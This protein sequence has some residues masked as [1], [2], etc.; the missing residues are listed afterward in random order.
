MS[1]GVTVGNVNNVI[2]FPGQ[3]G[4]PALAPATPHASLNVAR[5]ARQRIAAIRDDKAMNK[6]DKVR[7]MFNYIG[8][9]EIQ[10]GGQAIYAE[11]IPYHFDG[12]DR[13]LYSV[14]IKDAEFRAFLAVRYGLLATEEFTPKVVSAM[15]AFTVGQ[16][17][18]R[19]VRRF[20]YFDKA[21][22]TLYISAY[23]GTAWK[24]DGTRVTTVPNGEGVVF[25]DDDGG[26]PCQGVM[27]GAHDV[28]FP[29]LIN[30][31]DPTT[32]RGM[33]YMPL[34]GGGMTPDDQRCLFATWIFA[35]AFNELLPTK[36]LLL[37]TGEKGGGKTSCIQLVQHALF[38]HSMP[39]QVGQ[40]DEADFGVQLSKTVIALIDNTDTPVEWL[41]DALCAY[42]T[43][44]GWRRR[45]LY[46]NTGTIVIKPQAFVALATKNPE[47]FRRDDVADRCLIMKLARRDDQHFVHGIGDLGDTIAADR[48]WLLG[49]YLYYLNEIVALMR[50]GTVKVPPARHR[51]VD[52]ANLIHKIGPILGFTAE[53]ISHMFLQLQDERKALAL[54]DDVLTDVIDKWLD[55]TKNQGRQISLIDL[56][57]ELTTVAQDHKLRLFRSSK[58]LA[59]RLKDTETMSEHFKIRHID[60]AGMSMYE[61]RRAV[62]G[63]ERLAEA[64]RTNTPTPAPSN[65]RPAPAPSPAPSPV[66]ASF[67]SGSGW[68][69][70]LRRGLGLGK[71]KPDPK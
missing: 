12:L 8:A 32:G 11:Q 16:G 46:T 45:A 61:I 1:N 10:W 71:P 22:K 37:I 53:D 35:L 69:N 44:A 25:A 54:E 63:S 38:G 4:T 7:A 48:P 52:Y 64:P 23:N 6:P 58:T 17:L 43:G 40:R 57:S 62:P 19:N 13:K 34:T 30:T 9:Q 66:P 60:A 15:E 3:H 24:I 65:R 41:K 2:P 59:R 33:N 26:V 18:K 55:N 56:F 39:T 31:M 49:E 51:M 14:D 27:V 21:T 20:S 29:T 67:S 5:L 42:A 50:T 28:L 70:D 68:E 36:P 47:T